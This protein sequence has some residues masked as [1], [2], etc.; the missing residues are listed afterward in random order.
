MRGQIARLAPTLLLLTV[1]LLA[2]VPGRAPAA[3]VVRVAVLKFGTVNWELDVVRAHGLDRAHGFELEV[4][5]LAG[6]NATSVALQAGEVDLIVSDWVWVARERAAGTPYS[7]VPYSTGL[8]AVMV[9][10]DSPVAS[11]ADLAGRRLGVAGGPLDKSWLLLQALARQ[12]HGLDLAAAAEPVFAAPPLL[13][14]QLSAGRLDAVVTFWPYAA[15]LEAQGHRRLIG[16]AEIVEALGVEAELPLVGYVF[17]EDWARA[18]PRLLA[19]FV[20]ATEAA[21][22]VMAESDAEWQRLR[23]L[24]QA[25][26]EAVFLALRD[27]FRAGIPGPWDETQRRAAARLFELLARLG[28]PALVGR[29]E[30]LPEGTFWPGS[31]D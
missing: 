19:G 22:R 21:R 7:F 10:A 29:A 24:M 15:R 23:P 6:K 30:R 5:P 4:L 16:V 1:C 26:D 12:R 17:R 11:V 3:D 13:N 27:N 8:G 14:E 2:A 28:G 9:P 18:D 20:A 31:S 25:E